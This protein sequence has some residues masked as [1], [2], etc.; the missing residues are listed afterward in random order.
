MSDPM[1]GI[2]QKIVISP[3]VYTNL[4]GATHANPEM[5]QEGTLVSFSSPS[6]ITGYTF[7]GWMPSQI[8]TDMTGAQTVNAS[9]TANSYSISYNANG[10]SGIMDATSATYDAE[11]IVSDNGFTYAGY[12]FKGWSTEVGGEVVYAAGQPVT[13]LTAQAGGVVQLYA[14][15]DRAEGCVV[16]DGVLKSVYLG[17]ST[18]VVIPDTVTK[19]GM[20]AFSNCDKLVRVVIGEGVTHINASAFR[21]C[22][23]LTDIVIGSGVKR[24][25]AY[26]FQGCKKLENVVIKD[27]ASVIGRY[28]FAN[29]TSLTNLVIPGSVKKICNFAFSNC[30]GLTEAIIENGV[31]RIGARA[32]L[33]CKSL[34]RVTIPESVEKIGESAFNTCSSLEEIR[35]DGTTEQWAGKKGLFGIRTGKKISF[36][37]MW[38]N[39]T[40]G[41]SVYCTDGTVSKTGGV[42]IY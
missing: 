4:R 40:G 17:N 26:V 15:W 33:Y 10:G 1:T 24:M 35:Y 3:I 18:S 6:D 37:M 8:T 21:G 11:A 31:G 28:A 9:W 5:S 14:V 22:D 27:G 29:C 7:A 32:F 2:K 23:S 13:N 39:Q 19:I 38:D 36:G 16:V 20:A 25:G 34:T 41:Y 12:V 42:V 30:K